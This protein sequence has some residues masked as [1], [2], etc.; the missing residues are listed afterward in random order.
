MKSKL[1][2]ILKNPANKL[3]AVDL[4]WTLCTG[5]FWKEEC[6]PIADR[7]NYINSLYKKWAHII[8]RT[9]RMPEHY[10]VTRKWLEQ[11]NIMY[12]WISMH[13]KIW[14]DIYI[15]DKALHISDVFTN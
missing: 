4:D 8:I 10:E 5:K 2:D 12:H 7:I 6:K 15:D 11:H 13:T 9:A 1:L 3:I 14:A